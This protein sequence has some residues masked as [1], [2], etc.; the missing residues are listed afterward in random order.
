[1]ALVHLIKLVATL[2][3]AAVAAGR[4]VVHESRPSPPSGFVSLGP[5]PSTE[6]LTLRVALTSNNVAGLE[7]KLTSL[8]TPGS[9]EFRQW[10]SMEEV[11]SFVQPSAATLTTFNTWA[12]ANGLNPTPASPNGDWVSFTLPVSQANTLFAANFERF[13]HPSVTGTLTRTLSVSLPAELVGH[14]DVVHPTVDFAGIDP[15]LGPGAIRER[16]ATPPASCDTSVASGQMNPACLQDLYG[17]PTAPATQKSNRLLVTAYVEEFAEQADLSTFLEEFRPDISPNTTFSLLT[18]DNGTN[19]Q[20]SGEGGLEADLDIQYTVGIATGVPVQFLSVGGGFDVPGFGTSL[21]DTTVYLDGVAN[22][23]AVMTTSYGSAE[24]DFGI[25]LATKICNGYMALGARGISVIFASGD[26]GP[27]GNHD[28]SDVCADNVF[29]PVFPADCPYVTSVGG[30]IGFAPEK[31]VNFTGGGFS[32]FFPAPA[33]QS[34]AIGGF[35]KTIPSNFAGVFNKT[36]RGFPDVAAQA[37][38]FDVILDESLILVFGTSAAAPTFASI[39]ALIND[40]LVAAG[41]PVLGFLNPFIYSKA[42]KAFTDVTIGHN[43][44]FVCPASTVAFDAVTGWDALT[45]F[46]TPIFS[47]LLAAAMEY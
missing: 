19:P 22:P 31:A 15:R 17:I 38:N 42:S 23:P 2:S 18:L 46:G 7:Q 3:L 40:R 28:S 20:G 26:G 27:R 8:A 33:Y 39:V 45:G 41:K 43:S 24:S 30:T 13:T 6:M 47:K 11:K 4:M 37:W 10:L 34:A 16:G 5:A 9:A 14:V 1:M 21:L 36:G 35:L 12:S 44:G 29:S 25:S 32:N